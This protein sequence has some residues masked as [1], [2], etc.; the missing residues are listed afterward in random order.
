MSNPIFDNLVGAFKSWWDA[1]RARRNEAQ[2]AFPMPDGS[3]HPKLKMAVEDEQHARN[4]LEMWA[5]QFIVQEVD[6]VFGLAQAAVSGQPSKT[7]GTLT[8]PAGYQIRHKGVL[9]SGPVAVE[10]GDVIELVKIGGA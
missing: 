7:S 5:Q 1:E 8:P 3:D 2:F 4:I 10:I 9:H 6:R